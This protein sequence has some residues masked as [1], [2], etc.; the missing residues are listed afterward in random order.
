MLARR[1]VPSAPVATTVRIP[2]G[3]S[4]EKGLY[5]WDSINLLIRRW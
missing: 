1:Q 3:W 4:N 2:L 5:F